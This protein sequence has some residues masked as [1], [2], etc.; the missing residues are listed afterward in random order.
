MEIAGLYALMC[1]QGSLNTPEVREN[2]EC[3]SRSIRHQSGITRFNF[4]ELNKELNAF[5]DHLHLDRFSIANEQLLLL[6]QI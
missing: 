5:I 6:S 3:I 2:A 1:Q 4:R